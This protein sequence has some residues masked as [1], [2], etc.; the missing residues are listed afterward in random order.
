MDTTWIVSADTGRARIFSATDA[1]SPL[2]EV[3]TMVNPNARTRTSDELTDRMSPHAA[4]QSIHGSGGAVPSKQYEPQQTQEQREEEMFAREICATLLRG[5]QDNQF[6]RIALVAAPRF[7]GVL[8]GQLDPQLKQM[9]SFEI[10]KD[11][12]HSSGQQLRDQI[13]AHMAKG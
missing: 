3:Q 11:Y 7:L 2:L 1:N 13:R 9:V 8:R 12:A 6:K 10:D 5:K 4:G